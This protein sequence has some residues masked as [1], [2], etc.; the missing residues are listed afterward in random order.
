MTQERREKIETFPYTFICKTCNDRHIAIAFTDD[1][2]D[3]LRYILKEHKE[4]TREIIKENNKNNKEEDMD[5]LKEELDD[6]DEL[7]D[8]I[9]S[10]AIDDEGSK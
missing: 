4:L 8:K 7:L 5:I 6:T 2:L 1:Q 9:N 10:P 3:H